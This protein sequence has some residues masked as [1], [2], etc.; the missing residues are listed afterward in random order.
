MHASIN[1]MA[2][3]QG[4]CL[5]PFSDTG[6]RKASNL[7]DQSVQDTNRF[8]RGHEHSRSATQPCVRVYTRHRD[9]CY[10]T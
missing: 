5:S 4:F 6:P 3:G 2:R 9:W 8:V 1:G 10:T 7:P